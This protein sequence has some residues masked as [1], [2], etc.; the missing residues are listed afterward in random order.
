M[1]GGQLAGEETPR[2]GRVLTAALLSLLFWGAAAVETKYPHEAAYDAF[3]CGSGES[4]CPLKGDLL[5]YL[6]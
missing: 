2:P 3:L 6:W 4:C 5:L 1:V